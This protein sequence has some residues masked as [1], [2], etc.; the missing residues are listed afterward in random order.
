MFTN[1]KFTILLIVLITIFNKNQVLSAPLDETLISED[2]QQNNNHKNNDDD[3]FSFILLHNNDMHARFEEI[4]NMTKSCTPDLK[5]SNQ[6]FGGFARQVHVIREYREKAKNPHGKPILYLNAGDT[7]TGTP[8]FAIY[9][10]EIS[11][12]FLNLL[13]PD[14]VTLGNHEFDLGVKNLAKYIKSLNTPV[15]VSNLDLSNE[16]KMQNIKNLHNSIILE[17]ASHR[18]GIIGYVTPETMFQASVGKVKILPEIDAINKEAENLRNEGVNIIIALGHSGIQVDKQIAKHCPEVDIV[19]GAHTHTFLYKGNQ[20]DSDR[21]FDTYPIVV[22]QHGT[23]KR[24]PVVQAY[25]YTKYL[26]HLEVTFDKN[27]NLIEWN[28]NPILLDYS[29]PQ[30]NDVLDLLE[31]YRP[32]L[33]V[34]TES[35]GQTMN[36]LNGTKAACRRNECNFGDLIC[37][38]MLYVREKELKE[39]YR[40]SDVFISIIQAGGIKASIPRGNV[41]KLDILTAIPFNNTLVIATITGQTLV[42]ALQHSASFYDAEEDGG[43]LQFSGIRVTYNMSLPVGRRLLNVKVRC[44]E[45]YGETYHPIRLDKNYKVMFTKFLFT[46]GDQYIW[47]SNSNPLEEAEIM[48][49]W[50]DYLAAIEYI[51][52]MSPINYRTDHR[53]VVLV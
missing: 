3:E 18:I 52:D 30:D 25:A 12:K 7:F 43:Y 28:G 15:V 48:S 9:K 19:V 2:Q 26:G 46:G 11:S 36:N 35:I 38:A 10:H 21:P 53:Q 23:G 33:L 49:N 6:C 1:I 42:N 16:P 32:G 17:L 51:Q 27:G 4:Y 8:W 44:S 31:E 37:E 24:V 29:V 34:L 45:C 13:E 22:K 39:K 41:S 40:R 14:A 50:T 47:N 20:P 5:E